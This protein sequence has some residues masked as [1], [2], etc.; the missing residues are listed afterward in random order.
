MDEFMALFII[1]ISIFVSIFLMLQ[2]KSKKEIIATCF[3]IA[4]ALYVN[5]YLY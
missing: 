2:I 4:L 5:T 1:T 3:L